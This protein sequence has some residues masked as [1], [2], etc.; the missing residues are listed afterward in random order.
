MELNDI[1]FDQRNYRKHSDENKALIKKYIRRL[2]GFESLAEW[3][4]I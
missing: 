2:G 3:G 1:K 4:L